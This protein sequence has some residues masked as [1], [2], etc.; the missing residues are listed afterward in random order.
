[1]KPAVSIIMPA[2]KVEKYIT[3]AIESVLDIKNFDSWELIVVNDGSPDDSSEIAKKFAREDRRIKVVD[4]PNGGLSDARNFGLEIASGEYIHFFDSDDRLIPDNYS[5]LV[6]SLEDDP[7]ILI[8]GYA[9]EYH[10]DNTLQDVIIEK[11]CVSKIS[12][13]EGAINDCLLFVN[14]AW[15]KFFKSSF[16]KD[17]SLWYKKGLSR[18]EDV[19]FMSRCVDYSPK[20]SFVPTEGYIYVQRNESTLSKFYDETLISSLLNRRYYDAKVINYFSHFSQDEEELWSILTHKALRSIFASLYRTDVSICPKDKIKKI[21]Q[22][23]SS[24]KQEKTNLQLKGMGI[25]SAILAMAVKLQWSRL[26]HV[27]YSRN[28]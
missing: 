18:I 14:Y 6:S 16:L 27:L 2:Y 15:N 12:N 19:E 13:G 3:A 28:I 7:D 5:R 8:F 26:I 17:N 24:I 9:V 21:S 25:K 10:Q 20:I 22:I 1:M 4:K 23:L 11:P